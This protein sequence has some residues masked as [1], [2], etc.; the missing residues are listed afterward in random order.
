[1]ASTTSVRV[2]ITALVAF[3]LCQSAQAQPPDAPIDKAA[4]SPRIS[5]S[6]VSLLPG[7]IK[8]DLSCE[9]ETYVDN[10]TGARWLVFRIRNN[11]QRDMF[12]FNPYLNPSVGAPGR[13]NIH[14]KKGDFVG[15]L[16]QLGFGP[17]SM[18]GLSPQ[19]W[20]YMEIDSAIEKR[21][22]LPDQGLKRFAD[23][24]KYFDFS[25]ADFYV[26]IVGDERLLSTP[27]IRNQFR[28]GTFDEIQ[29]QDKKGE[30]R[31]VRS[32]P[33]FIKMQQ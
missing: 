2:V 30:K 27:S 21:V 12:V 13:I 3:V 5:N 4:P 1:M 25:K 10:T 18:K 15:D 8:G 28:S 33:V 6:K 31:I 32:K 24:G 23:T 16:L 26:Q 22:Q 20:V 29:W 7:E 9:L 17:L 11:A 19:S 14:D